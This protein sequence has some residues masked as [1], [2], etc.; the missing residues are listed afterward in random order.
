MPAQFLSVLGHIPPPVAGRINWPLRLT[1]VPGS[2]MCAPAECSVRT[3]RSTQIVVSS[4]RFL[5]A[6]AAA[7]L[8][9]GCGG[10]GDSAAPPAAVPIATPSA[11]FAPAS[12]QASPT[13]G[14]AV[15]CGLFEHPID[16]LPAPQLGETR[17]AEGSGCGPGR[18]PSNGTFTVDTSPNWILR[19]AYTCDGVFNGMGDPAVVFTAHNTSSGVDSSPVIQPGPWGYGAGGLTGDI[20]GASPPVGTYIVLVTVANPDL[21]RCQWRAAVGR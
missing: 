4:M 13:G 17:V 14:Q 18:V 3:Q 5:G 9:A 11:S 20:S 19:F 21:H 16:P 1:L 15:Q 10:S 6:L 2:T 7:F 12:P 8:L